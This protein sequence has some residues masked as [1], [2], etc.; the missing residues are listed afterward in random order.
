MSNVKNI[1]GAIGST[2]KRYSPEILT[3]IGIVGMIS[4]TVLAVR[5]TPKAL[6][7][8][9][10]KKRD[11]K[12][13]RIREARESGDKHTDGSELKLTVLETVKTTWKCYIPAVVTGA[14]STACL[15][16]ASSVNARR[17]AA[18]AA[19]YAISETALSDYKEKVFETL[20]EKKAEEVKDA[21]ARDK[22]E[23][24]PVDQQKIIITDKGNT[25]CYDHLSGRYFKSDVEQIRRAVNSLNERLLF[26]EHVCLNEFYDEIGL[27]EI[28]PIGDTLGWT[29]NPDS[30]DKGLIQLEFSSQ[31]A[32]GDTPCIVVG[33]S[34][35]PIYEYCR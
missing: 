33:F 24:N 19:A 28:Y 9:E 31:L 7:L 13:A 16:G 35:P 4:T 32:N 17:N 18:L 29:V 26:D 14:C 25:L 8:L 23:K 5:A 1:F 11:I 20:G 30:S 27:E 2:A 10:N 6:V 12:L 21:I 22:I 34:N 3:G 15:V